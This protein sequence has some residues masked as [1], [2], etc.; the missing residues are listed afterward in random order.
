MALWAAVSC[1]YSFLKVPSS[2]LSPAAARTVSNWASV[3][4]W[5]RHRTASL[6]SA[7]L[8]V[9]RASRQNEEV[10]AKQRHERARTKTQG[11]KN[12]RTD[13]SPNAVL[14]FEKLQR[15]C[16]AEHRAPTGQGRAGRDRKKKERAQR[17]FK[18]KQRQTSRCRLPTRCAQRTLEPHGSQTLKL[19][20]KSQS[21]E[22]TRRGKE[23]K[24]CTYASVRA[25]SVTVAI[26]KKKTSPL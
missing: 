2:T 12:K 20:D 25:A 11:E 1:A 7:Q 16:T 10:P 23:E 24:R 22:K 8:I 17:V 26:S 5:P 14:A 9:C 6:K 13:K 18:K 15:R 4:G 3:K 21:P 19:P